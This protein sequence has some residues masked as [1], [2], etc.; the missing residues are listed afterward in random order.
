M[1]LPAKAFSKRVVQLHVGLE[2]RHADQLMRNLTENISKYI[3]KVYP[4]GYSIPRYTRAK[5]G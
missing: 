3:Q 2:G 5:R 4:S 1:P